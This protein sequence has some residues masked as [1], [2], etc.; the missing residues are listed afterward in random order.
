MMM[1]AMKKNKAD[2]EGQD[3]LGL[4]KAMWSQR[5]GEDKSPTL[6]ASL[7]WVKERVV[8]RRALGWS[9]QVCEEPSK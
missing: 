8:L 4:K 1:S 6:S 3:I 5:F 7:T 2:K 9:V